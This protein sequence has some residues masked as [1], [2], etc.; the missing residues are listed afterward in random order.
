MIWTIFYYD[1]NGEGFSKACPDWATA[2]ETMH[3]FI[4]MVAPKDSSVTFHRELDMRQPEQSFHAT[5]GV[6]QF[7]IETV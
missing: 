3:G 2:R 1:A 7:A 6:F 5:D 4:D